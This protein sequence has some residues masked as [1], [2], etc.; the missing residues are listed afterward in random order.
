VVYVVLFE[1]DYNIYDGPEDFKGNNF[2]ES[3]SK[4][5]TMV[6]LKVARTFKQLHHDTLNS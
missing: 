6:V 3:L 1:F 5:K 2:G 4:K